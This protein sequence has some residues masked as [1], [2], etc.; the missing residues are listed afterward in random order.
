MDAV[1]KLEHELLAV[2][3][4]NDVHLMLELTPPAPAGD[5]PAQRAPLRLALVLDRSGSMSGEPLEVVKQAAAFLVGRL[6]ADDRVA[7]VDYDSLATLRCPLL[8]ASDPFVMTAL[9]SIHPGGT[10][11]LSGGW[12]KGREQ[13]EAADGVRR[14]LLLT[15]GLANEG[16]TDPATL[17]QIVCGAAASGIGTTSIGVGDGFN[18]DLLG[19]LAT[20]AGGSYH[21][22]DSLDK[23][24]PIFAEEFEDLVAL[25]A[26]NVSVEIRP[27][28]AVEIVGVLNNVPVVGV[29]G[30]LQ[31]QL[32]D[33]YAGASMR[34]VARLHAP[35]LAALGPIKL[36]D[37]VLRYTALGDK[38]AQHEVVLPVVAN[39]VNAD[40]AA[41]A[42]PDAEVTEHVVILT[43]ARAAEEATRLADAGQFEQ[44]RRHLEGA[45]TALRSTA[46]ASTQADALLAQAE[47]LDHASQ[48]MAAPATYNASERKRLHADQ[49]RQS[50]GRPRRPRPPRSS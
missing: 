49:W 9:Q 1:A 28:D 3:S 5:Q 33:A 27:H 10:T 48:M 19:A 35:S 18:E 47:E 8:P 31:V 23:A 41:A 12:L 29:D 42:V 16:I 37:L 2:E 39:I 36:A 7:V 4:D 26:Q 43:A 46:P 20:A 11:N 22:I 17:A 14:I 40:E 24:A 32:G 30:G 21:W 15:D 13:L 44:A 34:L 45:A 6:G 25:V 50:T 38:I